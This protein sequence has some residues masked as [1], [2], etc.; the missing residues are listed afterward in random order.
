MSQTMILPLQPEISSLYFSVVIVQVGLCGTWSEIL[1][2]GFLASRLKYAV[3][4][5]Y[6]FH[7]FSKV[8]CKITGI[9][10]FY[11]RFSIVFKSL[12]YCKFNVVK[13]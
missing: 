11:L 7:L 9:I 13:H 8:S 2:T 5:I 1:K 12:Q 3:Q 4:K 6:S 10:I